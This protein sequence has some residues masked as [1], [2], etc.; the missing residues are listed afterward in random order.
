M[1]PTTD[2]NTPTCIPPACAA[3]EVFAMAEPMRSSALEWAKIVIANCAVHDADAIAR[4]RKVIEA[5]TSAERPRRERMLERLNS[6]HVDPIAE[7]RACV[8]DND[9][10]LPLRARAWHVLKSAQGN[11]VH[12][13]R[14]A[15]PRAGTPPT[16]GDAA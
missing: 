4:A 1:T 12:Q 11:N 8:L 3:P 2:S 10:P 14:V 9:A 13:S 6:A 16:G 15:F 5:N 7:A